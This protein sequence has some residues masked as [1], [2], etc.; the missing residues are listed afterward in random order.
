[1]VAARLALSWSNG[2]PVPG[3][4]ATPKAARLQNAQGSDL[5]S[6]LWHLASS[7]AAKPL[8]SL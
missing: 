2:L 6:G 4:E 8:R 7:A 3:S 5:A 1:L